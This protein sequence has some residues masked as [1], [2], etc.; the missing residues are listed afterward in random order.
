MAHSI[1]IYYYY[2]YYF[3]KWK[4]IHT[5]GAALF[6]KYVLF[7]FCLKFALVCKKRVGTQVIG[8]FL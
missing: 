6:L 8:V 3:I 5:K 7:F 1:F 2:Y 4:S